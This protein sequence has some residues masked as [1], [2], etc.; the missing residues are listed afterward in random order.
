M[1]DLPQAARKQLQRFIVKLEARASDSKGFVASP[2]KTLNTII[3]W[4][5]ANYVL[6]AQFSA[7]PDVTV[8]L[9]WLEAID[10]ALV[11]QGFAPLQSTRAGD[12]IEQA[13]Q[14]RHEVKHL[15]EAPTLF[16]VLVAHPTNALVVT[17]SA[18]QGAS[19]MIEDADWRAIDLCAYAV[20]IVVENLTV[21]YQLRTLQ[22]AWPARALIVYRGHQ[23]YHRGF[24]QLLQSWAETAQ[25]CYAMVDLDPFSIRM[26]QQGPYTHVAAPSL[27]RFGLLANAG[28]APAR[29]QGYATNLRAQGGFAPYI[30]LMQ[31]KQCGLKQEW[32]HAERL[33]WIE[34]S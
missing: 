18:R 19:W 10:K 26:L 29:Q 34:L 1:D 23:R 16:R 25:P 7:Q 12:R 5:E 4:A 30:T 17:D 33:Y 13:G 24:S 14:S 6:P 11:S 28:H 21:F 20:L 3:R 32:M 22:I 27:E 15:A 9:E 2:T 31:Q 8:T